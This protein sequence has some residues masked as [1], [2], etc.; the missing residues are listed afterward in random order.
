MIGDE[1]WK[2]PGTD[3]FHVGFYQENWDLVSSD[4][5]DVCL[6]ILNGDRSV[7]AL[8]A[9]HIV[10]IAKVKVPKK[11]SDFRPISLCNVIYKII[12][13]TL[14]NRLKVHLLEIIS[15]EQ[16]AF[17]PGRLITDNIIVAYETMHAIRRKTD[18]KK[19]LMALKLDMSKAYDRVEWDFLQVIMLKLGVFPKMGG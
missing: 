5:T 11:V 8:N 2:A 4:V 1:S 17:V 7:R 12:A 16:S 15:D 10:L 14:A 6:Q 13:K 3:R 19:G 18:G 9:T